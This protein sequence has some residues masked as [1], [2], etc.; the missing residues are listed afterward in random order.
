M[1]I[2]NVRGNR[3]ER[4]MNL[5]VDRRRESGIASLR[6]YEYMGGKV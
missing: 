6:G 4:F 3:G 5:K 2:L 1:V